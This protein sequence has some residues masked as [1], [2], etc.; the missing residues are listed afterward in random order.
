M[1]P[2]L[3][4]HLVSALNA[5]PDVVA[6]YLFG[7]LVHGG[8]TAQSE[9]DVAVLLRETPGLET[10]GELIAAC[11]DALERD[12][13]DLVVLNGASP[14][15]AFEAISGKRILTQDPETTAAFESI[16]S[17]EFEDESAR[18]ARAWRLPR[19]AEL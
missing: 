16:V 5:I 8:D 17:R 14:I 11:Q 18:C 3:V 9:A 15:P 19:P 2:D 1:S 12:D 13:V 10:V 7:S 4:E 6:A